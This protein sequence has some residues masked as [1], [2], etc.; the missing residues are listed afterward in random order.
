MMEEHRGIVQRW[1]KRTEEVLALEI[2]RK[3]VKDTRALKQSVSTNFSE[4]GYMLRAQILFL[5]HG[6]FVDMGAGR[7]AKVQAL[8]KRKPKKWY[9]PAFYGRLNMLQGALGLQMME[10]TM[11]ALKEIEDGGKGR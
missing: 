1:L 11:S 9:S 6:R 7:R 2:E 4:E 5:T 3:R 10:E 8:S